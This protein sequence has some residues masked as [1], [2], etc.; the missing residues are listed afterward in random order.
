MNRIASSIKNRLS[1]R[2]PQEGSLNILAGLMDSLALQKNCDLS[3]ELEKVRSAY[4]V[5][6]DFERSF[7]SIC[8]ALATG[9]G[10]T[11][12]MGA[13]I[14]YLYL[15]KGFRNF[16]VLAPN[17][18]I[19]NKLIVDFSNTTCPKYVFQGIGEFVHN[20]P[21]IVTG[22]NYNSIGDL[23]RE[24][25]IR[26]NVFNIS[27]INSEM[28]G[29]KLPRI[30]R[31]SEYLGYSYFNYLSGLDDLVL[32]MDESHH[33]RADRGMEVINE[34]N[35]ILGL[36]L[37]ATP[38]VERSGGAVKF[39]NVVYEYSLAKAI[40]DG[41]VKEPAVATRKDFDPGQYSPEDLDRIKLEDGIRIH[42]DTKV[43][44]D[45]FARDHRMPVVKPF[46][47]VVAKDTE[48]AGRLRELI[49]SSAFFEGHYE[50][51][52]MEIH[53]NQS[54]DEKD[55]N[56]DRLLSLESPD[57]RIEIVIHVNMLKEGW[58]VTNLY[59]II[60]LRTAAS[61]TLREQTIGRG[62]RLPYGKRTG[63]DKV[64][65][66][67]IV[68]HDRFQE[69][70]DAANRPDSII[71]KENIITIDAEELSHT[72]EVITSVPLVE[73]KIEEQQK[74][75]DSIAGPEEKQR[76]QI[77]LDVQKAILYMLPE[78][79]NKV[80]SVNGL[81]KEEIKEM[82]IEKIRESLASSPQQV[83]FAA[84]MIKDAENTYEMIVDEFA[85]NI[86]EIPRITIQQSGEIRS[87]FRDFDLDTNNLN[88]QPVSE[89]ILIRKL[90]E[91]ENSV[92]IVI[93][94][95]RII[96][97]VPERIIVNELMNYPE[98][99]YDEQSELLFKLTGQAIEKF[100][101]WLG[102]DQILNVVQYHKKE[103][104]RY[105]YSQLMV[106]FYCETTGFEQPVVKPFTKI[107]EHNF[108]KYT[109]DSIHH[110]TDTI[111]PTSA[112]PGKVFCGFRKACHNLYKFDS[113]T[114]KDF[115]IILENEAAV[116]KWMRPAQRQFH[117]YWRHNSKQ[118]NPDFIVETVDTI[119][120]VET[121]KEGAIDDQ[122]VQEKSQAALQHCKYATE[123][124]SQNSGKQWKYVL[125]P[126]NIVQANMSFNYLVRACET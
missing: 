12:L 103:I 80:T 14:A 9:V 56:I 108:S 45:I 83:M 41:F 76:A 50:D 125:I 105:I 5:C 90:R 64:D 58:D 92:D 111:T 55:E 65:K 113:K 62:L 39:K 118:Y 42:E 67:T 21:V 47:L 54:G 44:L 1:L 2:P 104:G 97:D 75:I 26:I 66:L 59:T 35:P 73:K 100:Q 126:H 10:K 34:L 69:I 114:E 15:A 120:M 101:S 4:P 109:K 115:A 20:N 78:L 23:F 37:T 123:F 110:Y 93:G 53:S 19:Y 61:T 89:E 82:A 94:R 107:E 30:K 117:I 6:T 70:I 116:L 25:E 40:R 16:F 71:R 102:A 112:I 52:V 49:V 51:K 85:K 48:H 22:D 96:P 28:R 31:L 88:Y 60:P 86:I 98:I 11:R 17:L 122:D 63:H 27:K 87:G 18:T 68:A 106:H 38:Q 43:A 119:Y 91:Q 77:S 29:G 124:T 81:K 79:N 84:E 32:L 99:N 74:V 46:V 72:K 7:P 36:E 121:K 95:G 57:N 33:Y 8:F 13:F 3:A 24:Q